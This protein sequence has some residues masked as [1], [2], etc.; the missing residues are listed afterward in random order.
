MTGHQLARLEFSS[1]L[2]RRYRAGQLA[3]AQMV[4]A[5]AGFNDEWQYFH[6]EPAGPGVM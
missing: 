5:L 3:D 1:A 6:V 2:Y 4:E